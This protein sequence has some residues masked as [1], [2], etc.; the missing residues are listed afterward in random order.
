MGANCLHA[1]EVPGADPR[2]LDKATACDPNTGRSFTPAMDA[3][4]NSGIR[5]TDFHVA[6]AVCTPSRSALQTGRVGARTGVTS[7][8]QPGS[9]SGL[10]LNET[11]LGEYLRPNGYTTCAIGK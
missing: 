10:P 2:N 4:A 1:A 3:L 8:F 9:L 5:F 6:A 7:N 11:T